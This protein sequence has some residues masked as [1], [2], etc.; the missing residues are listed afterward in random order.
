VLEGIPAQHFPGL[1]RMQPMPGFKDQ[2]DD[3]QVADLANWM[4]AQWGGEEPNVK[5]EDVAQI[6]RGE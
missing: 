3:R 5:P 6:R 1:E 2:L 4:R